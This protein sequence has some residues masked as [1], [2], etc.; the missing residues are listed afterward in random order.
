MKRFLI[1]Y[2]ICGLLL[3][4]FTP[5]GVSAAENEEEETEKVELTPGQTVTLVV[6]GILVVGVMLLKIMLLNTVATLWEPDIPTF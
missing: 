3:L 6:A 1:L 5:S 4:G 2:L